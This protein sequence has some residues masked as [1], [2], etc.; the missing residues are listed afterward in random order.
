MVQ[1]ILEHPIEP[2]PLTIGELNNLIARLPA[3]RRSAIEWSIPAVEFA[4]DRLLTEPLEP[5]LVEACCLEVIR[6]TLAIGTALVPVA[7]AS[8]VMRASEEL[9]EQHR[10]LLRGSLSA[11]AAQTADWALRLFTSVLRAGSKQ[12]PANDGPI[13]VLADEDLL[14]TFREPFMGPFFRLEALLFAVLHASDPGRRAADDRWLRAD[15]LAELAGRQAVALM[16][17]AVAL[18]L[19]LEI[20]DAEPAHLRV[21]IFREHAARLRAALSDEDRRILRDARLRDLR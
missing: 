13:P 8:E 3:E 20:F 2:G 10:G 12:L 15:A 18:G 9:L 4:L 7:P 11:E 19:R 6:A 16:N 21:R 14:R 1:P 17:D 5:R